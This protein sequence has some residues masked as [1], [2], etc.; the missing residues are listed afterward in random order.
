[1]IKNA[2]KVTAFA[3]LALVCVLLLSGCN[4]IFSSLYPT[5]S[6]DTDTSSSSTDSTI[7]DENETSDTKPS[8]DTMVD[9]LTI[10]STRIDKNGHLIISV[11]KPNPNTLC[12]GIVF[13]WFL[14]VHSEAQ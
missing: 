9:G 11:L 2:K 10:S 6:S 4:M 1:M 5:Y 8:P 3:A 12:L 14:Y 13:L 7:D